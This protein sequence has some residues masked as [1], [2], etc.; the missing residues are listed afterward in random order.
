[1]QKIYYSLFIY[2]CV[3]QCW[4]LKKKVI[5]F[6][7]M[8]YF[9]LSKRKSVHSE[10][11]IYVYFMHRKRCWSISSVMRFIVVSLLFS[12]LRIYI[13]SSQN[14]I[15]SYPGVS[16]CIATYMNIYTWTF[17]WVMFSLQLLID[18][19]YIL[20][21]WTNF[22]SLSSS[23]GG[24]SRSNGDGGE[25]GGGRRGA[26]LSRSPPGAYLPLPLSSHRL[27]LGPSTCHVE[28]PPGRGRLC[29][30]SIIQVRCGKCGQV[31]R[32]IEL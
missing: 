3:V 25:R 28:S 29:W 24:G 18:L 32:V 9:F 30:H 7:I 26:A 1:M 14:Q 31:D 27:P 12:F 22:L 10:F 16:L 13:I 23:G 15:F 20:Y 19:L 6:H 17:Y 5:S 8:H 2:S 21:P 11:I 4:I